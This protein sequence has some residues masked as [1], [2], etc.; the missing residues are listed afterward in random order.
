MSGK[1]RRSFS[2]EQKAAD[3]EV[4]L[5]RAREA[6]R[7]SVLSSSAT[8]GRSSSPKRSGDFLNQ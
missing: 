6:F 4:V 5:Q 8:T 3:M 7:T 1:Q 2:A